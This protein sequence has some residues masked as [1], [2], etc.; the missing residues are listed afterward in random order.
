MLFRSSTERN[1]A[2]GTGVRTESGTTR[3]WQSVG[4]VL[5][6]YWF[7][8]RDWMHGPTVKLTYQKTV[9]HQFSENGANST[10]MTFGQQNVDS[11]QTS[12]GWQAAGAIGAVRPFARVTWE[13]DSQADTR[14]VSA[15]LYG[16]GSGMFSV[17]SYQPDNNY[18]L[19]NLGA[20]TEFGKVTGY[21]TGSA[22]AGKSDGNY[23]AVTVGIRVPL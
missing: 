20:A 22:S 8:W 23:W 12:V 18:A 13:Y 11:F 7:N 3:G 19:F 4:R 15:N 5:G 1:I 2:L 14:N 17:P 10:T 9:V 21:L 6:G 16:T